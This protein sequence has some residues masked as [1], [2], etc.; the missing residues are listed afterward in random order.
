MFACTHCGNPYENPWLIVEVF[1]HVHH[2]KRVRTHRI[3]NIKK[4]NNEPMQSRRCAE[5]CIYLRGA[6][7]QCWKCKWHEHDRHNVFSTPHFRCMHAWQC[8]MSLITFCTFYTFC[9]AANVFVLG[10]A[11]F[12]KAELQIWRQ[13]N[14]PWQQ[15]LPSTWFIGFCVV[16]WLV[17]CHGFMALFC[18]SIFLIFSHFCNFGQTTAPFPVCPI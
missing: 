9:F 18:Q 10:P 15:I 13:M 3:C 6:P 2:L 16:F 12:H 17:P 5:L 1:G 14:L 8:D 7:M 11:L 4:C